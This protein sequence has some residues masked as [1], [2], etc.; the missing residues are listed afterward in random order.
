[1]LCI[2]MAESVQGASIVAFVESLFSVSALSYK[3]IKMFKATQ[4]QCG[5]LLTVALSGGKG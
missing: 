4:W 2:S 5:L 1:M 3:S